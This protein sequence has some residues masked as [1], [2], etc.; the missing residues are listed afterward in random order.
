MEQLNSNIERV[1]E[2]NTTIEVFNVGA[3]FALVKAYK[4]VVVSGVATKEK[5]N[6]PFNFDLYNKDNDKISA[7]TISPGEKATFKVPTYKMVISNTYDYEVHIVFSFGSGTVDQLKTDLEMTTEDIAAL[8]QYDKQDFDLLTSIE[9]QSVRSGEALSAIDN[10]I[11]RETAIDK[12]P[13]MI[14]KH[15][16]FIALASPTNVY[17]NL[18][19]LTL[20]NSGGDNQPYYISYIDISFDYSQALGYAT[21]LVVT[22]TFN[23]GMS[24]GH[25]ARL[26]DLTP[27]T[28]DN[29]NTYKWTNRADNKLP[30]RSKSLAIAGGNVNDDGHFRIDINDTFGSGTDFTIDNFIVRT[31]I[32]HN[33]N[34]GSD[35]KVAIR[36]YTDEFIGGVAE[37]T[38]K[39]L[40]GNYQF[41]D[42]NKCARQQPIISTGVNMIV[43][44]V[45]VYGYL[46]PD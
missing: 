22:N 35:S 20:K 46:L 15:P 17:F 3:F 38:E 26:K 41:R 7:G 29:W 2:A 42:Y 25:Y 16:I 12:T 44:D 36:K 9:T 5:I 40:V 11:A 19:D 27:D 31:D 45:T 33:K 37:V 43:V 18:F 10:I 21:D 32:S 23:P 30:T 24:F 1:I 4:Y 13:V 39:L 8:T 6:V 34:A 14:N 28:Q